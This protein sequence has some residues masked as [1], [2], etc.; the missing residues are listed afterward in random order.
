MDRHGTLVF[1]LQEHALLFSYSSLAR[2]MS[3]CSEVAAVIGKQKLSNR[4]Q[5][6][7]GMFGFCL[8]PLPGTCCNCGRLPTNSSLSP[9]LDCQGLECFRSFPHGERQSD[10]V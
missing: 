1:A 3:V 5:S 8:R 9:C 2:L 7:P 4:T 10:H 6:H